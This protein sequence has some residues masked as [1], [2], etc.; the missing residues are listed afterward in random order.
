MLAHQSNRDFRVTLVFISVVAVLLVPFPSAF[1]PASSPRHD[2]LDRPA[3]LFAL[4]STHIIIQKYGPQP[5]KATSTDG[6]GGITLPWIDFRVLS[7]SLWRC[8]F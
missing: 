6:R 7:F 8:D 2:P 3:R 4:A 1:T 5:K